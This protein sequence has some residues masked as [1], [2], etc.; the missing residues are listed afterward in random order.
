MKVNELQP[1]DLVTEQ[2][3]Q[4]TVAFEVVAIQQLG[5]RFAVTFRSALG[6]GSAHYAGDAWISAMRR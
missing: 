4:D 2:H 6:L 5:R 3:G 1:G